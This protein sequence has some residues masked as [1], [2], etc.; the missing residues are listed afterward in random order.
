MGFGLGGL[1][2][3]GLQ[4]YGIPRDGSSRIGSH[5]SVGQVGAGKK[6]VPVRNAD[7]WLSLS[8]CVRLN[9]LCISNL[10]CNGCSKAT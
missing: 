1:V 3:A 5:F 2:L 7:E 6:N 10:G 4:V 9:S 8:L